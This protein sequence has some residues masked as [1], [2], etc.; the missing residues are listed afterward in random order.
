MVVLFNRGVV[1]RF[2]ERVGMDHHFVVIELVNVHIAYIVYNYKSD[3]ECEQCNN[4]LFKLHVGFPVHGDKETDKNFARQ[5][6]YVGICSC[7][8][9]KNLTIY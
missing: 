2:I 5:Y 6:L 1:L 4:N 8:T 9:S 3:K 7:Q